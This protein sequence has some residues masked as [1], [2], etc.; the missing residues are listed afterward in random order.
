MLMLMSLFKSEVFCVILI[1]IFFSTFNSPNNDRLVIVKLV[2]AQC[3]FGKKFNISVY[4]KYTNVYC[5]NQYF[6]T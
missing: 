4:K 1:L 5:K 3:K 2:I 6:Y